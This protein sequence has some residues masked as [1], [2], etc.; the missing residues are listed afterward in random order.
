MQCMYVQ[1][2]FNGLIVNTMWVAKC[3]GVNVTK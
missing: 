1:V 3:F 2:M